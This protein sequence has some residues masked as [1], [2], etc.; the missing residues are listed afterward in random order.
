MGVTNQF[1]FA[2]ESAFRQVKAR[3]RSLQAF[4]LFE[5]FFTVAD[6]QKSL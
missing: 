2:E 1:A 3:S 5:R 6:L 4:T